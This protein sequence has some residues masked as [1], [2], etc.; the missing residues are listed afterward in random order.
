MI[1]N[2]WRGERFPCDGPDE[3]AHLTSRGA[4][5]ADIANAVILCRKHHSR[6]HSMG[7]TSFERFYNINLQDRAQ[8]LAARWRAERGEP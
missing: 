3:A 1:L 7:A 2:R 5:G 6:Q 4:G 8:A